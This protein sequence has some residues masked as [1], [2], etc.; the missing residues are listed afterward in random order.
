MLLAR[1]DHKLAVGLVGEVFG[2]LEGAVGVVVGVDEDK[3][4]GM[5]FDGGEVERLLEEAF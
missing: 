1:Y 2:L 3:L 5:A 4:F